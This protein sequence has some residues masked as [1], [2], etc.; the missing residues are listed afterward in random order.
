MYK[1]NIEFQ[2]NGTSL[3]FFKPLIIMKLI[4]LLITVTLFQASAVTK[5]QNVTFKVNKAS[6]EDVFNILHKQTGYNFI[7]NSAMLEET[8]PVDLHVKNMPLE[9]VLRACFKDQS[10]KYVIEDK[11]VVL[12]KDTELA[13]NAF[14]PL[15]VTGVVYDRRYNEVLIGVTVRVKGTQIGAVTDANG[16]FTIEVPYADAVLVFSYIG[17]Q[18]FEM[19]LQGKKQVKV[20]MVEDSRALQEVVVVGYNKQRK[21]TLIGSVA[22]ITTKDL[23]QSP[24]ANVNNAL[25]G[26]LPGLIANQYRGGEVGVDKSEIFIRGKATYG[27][28]SP[29]V[30]IDGVERDM[31]YLAA[32]EIETFT[33]LKDA[34]A[35][36][37]Y[38][39]RGANGVI[40]ISTKRGQAAEKATVNFKLATGFNNPVKFPTYLGSADY[41]V[42]YNEAKIN[43]ARMNGSDVSS[44]KLFSQDAIDKFRIAKGDNSDGMGYNWDYFDYIFKTSMQQ[45]YSLSIRGGT[46]K[47]RYYVLGSFFNQGGNFKHIDDANADVDSKFERYN[48][49]SNIDINITDNFWARLDLG[50]R[51]TDRTSPGTSAGKVITLAITQPSYLPIT[52]ENNENPANASFRVNN[53]YGMLYGNNINRLNVLG[54]LSRTGYQNEKN[55][56]LEGT[57]ALGYNL[58]FITKG[59]KAEASFSYDASEGRWLRRDVD[60]YSEGYAQYPG[61]ATFTPV[62][63]SDIYMEPGHYEGAYQN[64]NKYVID[65]TL[66]NDLST[67][68]HVSKTYYQFR[69]DYARTFNEIHEVSGMLLFNRSLRTSDKDIAYCYQGLTGRAAYYYD[70]K[71]LA[72]FN[73]GYNGSENFA[74]DKRYGFF[75]AASLG[76]IITNESFMD[77]SKSWLDQL[78]I[79]ASYGIVGS[80]KIAGDRFAYLSYYNTTD[81][82]FYYGQNFG[83]SG[84]GLVEGRLPNEI[85]TWEKAKKTNIGLDVV[86]FNHRLSTTIDI[87]NEDRYDIIT[88]LNDGNNKVGFPSVVGKGA[89]YVNLGKVR[90]RG[91][92]FELSWDDKIG[93]DFRYYIKPNFTF[94]RNKL[95]YMNE[96]PRLN[97]WR[98]ETGKSLGLNYVYVFDHFVADASEATSLNQSGYQTWGTLI[99]GDAVYKDLNSD[100]VIDDNDRT[101]MGHPRSPEI[102]FGIPLGVQYKHFDLSFLFQGATNTSILLSGA[103]AWDFPQYD[104][105]KIGKV[106]NMHFN[107]WTPETASTA[108]Y[109]ALHMGTHNNN[110]NDRSSLYLYDAKYL[111]LKNIEIGYILPSRLSKVAGLQQVRIYAQ[112]LNLLTWDGLDDA[113]IDPETGDGWGAW[114]PI[115]KIY[116][117]GI[118]VTF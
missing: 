66:R 75:P 40:V 54:E 53:P 73:F 105:D 65:Q 110:K 47:A 97:N 72:E 9:H 39:I 43:D 98:Q 114:Y 42:L 71:Y 32:D 84:T 57:F 69:T 61:Y 10:L 59:L 90:N 34:S 78:K 35:T 86:F 93:K 38:G 89:P 22:T 20:Y 5:A 27:D 29:I 116:N 102:Q 104:Q 79:R 6:L 77:R 68:A 23:Q 2:C 80:D 113:D 31:S 13:T 16:K 81:H 63:G 118:N 49:R 94:A 103:A 11:T 36:A 106:K 17:Y 19:P 115:Q 101:S 52:I 85:I 12:Y 58:N 25:A 33:I 70:K 82:S 76:W 4:I 1:F 109:P 18:P 67:N 88:N 7:Y 64:G 45:D 60:Y 14:P 44:L 3:H 83:S 62:G 8:N 74:P 24:T 107:R 96:I 21:E 117:L 92:D 112:G 100:G 87:F 41:A 37:A 91:V 15:K 28:Q 99:P 95:I 55:T 26:R 51:I 48:F 56:Y 108:T 111:R 46:D 30:I 50:A